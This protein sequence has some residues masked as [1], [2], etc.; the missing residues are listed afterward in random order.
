MAPASAP[1]T[2]IKRYHCLYSSQVNNKTRFIRH[3]HLNSRLYLLSADNQPLAE[4]FYRPPRNQRCVFDDHFTLDDDQELE[5]D[6]QGFAV[7]V[8]ELES[9]RNVDLG[10][11]QAQTRTAKS[12]R[13]AAARQ[14]ALETPSDSNRSKEEPD[15]KAGFRLQD[16][17]V[18]TSTN[19]T[20]TTPKRRQESASHG[21][22]AGWFTPST[23]TALSS[24]TPQASKSRPAPY[25][26]DVTPARSSSKANTVDHSE[27]RVIGR[28][29]PTRGARAEFKPPRPSA[30]P[31][32]KSAY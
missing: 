26:K 12:E 1:S 29:P 23:G 22:P 27:A 20:H 7:Q 32:L 10:A 13:L 25:S 8:G 28:T 4:S 6:E 17:I 5:F 19:E 30:A 14:W 11:I 21:S 18:T 9:E 15:A 2:K 16:L 24:V 31:T 3:H